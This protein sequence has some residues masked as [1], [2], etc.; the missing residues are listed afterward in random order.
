[1]E[2]DMTFY[3][4]YSQTV[5]LSYDTNG[6]AQEYLPQSKV[7]NYNASGEYANPSFTVAK[8]PILSDCSFVT[9]KDLESG[10]TYLA[11]QTIVLSD[12]TLLTAVWDRFPELSAYNRYFTLEQA[13]NGLITQAALLEKVSA[14]DAE[15]G[16]L[17]N[18]VNVIVLNYEP[19]IF[20]RLAICS[21]LRFLFAKYLAK[22]QRNKDI[23]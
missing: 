19:S 5:E 11:N 4:R 16:E 14:T 2:Q 17:V 21:L 6:S 9:W 8:E 3:G 18:G 23:Y 10:N 12:S 22:M 1:M 7:R 13:Q 15:D 20:D